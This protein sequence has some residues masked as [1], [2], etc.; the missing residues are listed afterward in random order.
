MM[1]YLQI[2]LTEEK[3]FIIMGLNNQIANLQARYEKATMKA[4]DGE[5]L[6]IQIKNSAVRMELLNT[7]NFNL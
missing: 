7:L 1:F 4:L 3:K 6:L 5:Q 2:K